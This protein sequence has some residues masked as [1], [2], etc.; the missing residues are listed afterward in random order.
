M[1]IERIVR[2]F[3]GTMVLLSLVLAREV[4]PFFYLVTAFVGVNLLQSSLSGWCLL[5]TILR[6]LGVR[7]CATSTAVPVPRGAE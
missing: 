4:S 7:D 2:F 5:V 1:C 3:A 6:R